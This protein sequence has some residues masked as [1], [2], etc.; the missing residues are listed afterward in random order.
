MKPNCD[1]GRYHQP[2][3]SFKPGDRVRI[4]VHWRYRH[5]TGTVRTGFGDEIVYDVDLD[6]G[7]PGLMAMAAS[8]LWREK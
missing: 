8:E 5:S 3:E 4:R 7:K 2:A 1:C 6:E